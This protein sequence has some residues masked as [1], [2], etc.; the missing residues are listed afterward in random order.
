MNCAP[1]FYN[2]LK[3]VP[4]LPLIDLR[5]QD[6]WPQRSSLLQDLQT[7]CW[8]SS[9]SLYAQ[10]TSVIDG[11]RFSAPSPFTNQNKFPRH[12][13][14]TILIQNKENNLHKMSPSTNSCKCKCIFTSSPGLQQPWNMFSNTYLTVQANVR[15][16]CNTLHDGNWKLVHACITLQTLE[17]SPLCSWG[18]P[19]FKCQRSETLARLDS[20]PPLCASFEIATAYY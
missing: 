7:V 17:V 2:A 10:F 3:I 18:V 4:A 11:Y 14:L 16:H 6:F 13:L 15:V 20:W 12:L 19:S 8:S 5:L 1:W 9:S